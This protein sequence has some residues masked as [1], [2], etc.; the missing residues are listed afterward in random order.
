M[1]GV[2]GADTRGARRPRLGP[3]RRF[4]RRPSSVDARLHSFRHGP[5]R[6]L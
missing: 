1:A 3:R 6:Q 2:R 5:R 4:G